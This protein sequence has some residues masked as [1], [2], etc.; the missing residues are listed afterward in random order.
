MQKPFILS[1]LG[2]CI[3][4]SLLYSCAG[5]SGKQ[6]TT[7][8][9][10]LS[11]AQAVMEKYPGQRP[12]PVSA[13][14]QDTAVPQPYVMQPI[15]WETVKKYQ[16]NYDSDPQLKTPTGLYYKGFSIDTAGYSTLIRTPAIKSL[17]LRLGRRDDGSYTV[18]IL[19]MDAKGNIIHTITGPGTGYEGD[20]P[21]NFDNLPPCPANCPPLDYDSIQ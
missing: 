6:F 1:L 16:S 10:S 12:A 20:E 21:T 17:Y 8:Q 9:D 7:K 2:I 5:N 4:C 18:M 3:T 15:T 13:S 11:F 14:L 19:G